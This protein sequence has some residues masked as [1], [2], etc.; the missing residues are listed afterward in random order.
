M[1]IREVPPN[2]EYLINS[3]RSIGY[4]FKTAIADIIDNSLSASAT[5][6]DILFLWNNSDCEVTITDNGCG[7]S[8][9]E[10]ILA[11]TFAGKN[12]KDN[13]EK[14]DLGRFGL[15]LKSASLSQARILSVYSKKNNKVSSFE[16][17]LNKLEALGDG[18]W[19]LSKVEQIP[20]EFESLIT[21]TIVRWKDLDGIF[22]PGFGESA[23]LDLMDIVE[24]HISIIFHKYIENGVL[25]RING[26]LVAPLDPFFE[27]S[28]YYISPQE[29]IGTNIEP[30][31]VKA[32]L[33]REDDTSLSKQN[34]CFIYRGER[35]LCSCGLNDL[36]IS[37]KLKK[38]NLKV[39]IDISN[40][41]DKDWSIDIIKSKAIM[42][43]LIKNKL[44]NYL[45][46]LEKILIKKTKRKSENSYENYDIWIR[47]DLNSQEYSIN[48]DAPILKAFEKSL[49]SD[50]KE[51]FLLLIKEIEA[52]APKKIDHV[53]V[54][55]KSIEQKGENLS[56]DAKKEIRLHLLRLIKGKSLN[57]EQAKKK[58]ILSGVFSGYERDIEI[59]ANEIHGE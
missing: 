26:N 24:E 30:V 25:I 53:I 48:K 15:G 13:R 46:P 57:V 37:S 2:A 45:K 50:L 9:E 39:V 18:V 54:T 52:N 49:S 34:K 7:M 16:W 4:Q 17:N 59:I 44:A 31:K 42:P 19:A 6:I 29:N 27:E 5:E 43:I 10:L 38:T 1:E 14:I 56:V 22:T 41:S 40:S 28:V 20:Y 21:G 32:F 8:E 51:Q 12:V 11:M 33:Y 36:S 3:L 58:V 23:F 35:L 55:E 47:N